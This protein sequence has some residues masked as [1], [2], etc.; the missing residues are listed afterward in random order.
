LALALGLL[1]FVGA[2]GSPALAGANHH[3]AV[4]EIDLRP[5]SKPADISAVAWSAEL[6]RR[7]R[8]TANELLNA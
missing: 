3:I 4:A 8:Q 1:R 2:S 6:W 5:K 7:Q